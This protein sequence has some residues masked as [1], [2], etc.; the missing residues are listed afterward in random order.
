M[1]VSEINTLF[2]GKCI[3]IWIEEPF[4]QFEYTLG[5][6]VVLRTLDRSNDSLKVYFMSEETVSNLINGFD[7]GANAIIVKPHTIPYF[8][9]REAQ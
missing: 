9:L 2:Y 6:E 1:K 4:E 3:K 8:Q 7:P 5:V